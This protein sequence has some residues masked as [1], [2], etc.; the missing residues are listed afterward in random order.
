MKHVAILGST[1]SVG[2]NCLDVI[3]R[4]RSRFHVAALTTNTQTETLSIQIKEFEPT[5]CAIGD[6]E[7]ADELKNLLAGSKIQV[8]IGS[9]GVVEAAVRPEVDLVVNALVG[10]AGLL[11]TIKAIEAGKDIALANKESLVMAGELIMHMA[12]ESRIRLIPIDSEHSGILQCLQGHSSEEV[13]RI[14][15]TASGGPLLNREPIE[16]ESISPEEALA[17]PTWEMG[18]KITIDSASLMNKGLEV[19][20]AHWLFGVPLS[21][22][23]VVVHPQSIIHSLVEFTDGSILA[24]MGVPDM[25]VPIQLALTFPQRLNTPYNRLDL[26]EVR[27]LSFLQPDTHKFPCLKLAYRAAENGGTLP[28]VLNAANERA[29]Q[30][31]LNHRIAFTRIPV[32]IEEALNRHEKIDHPSLDEIMKADQWSRRFVQGRVEGRMGRLC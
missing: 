22:I 31:F 18:P 12:A 29:V 27:H 32:L 5:F 1:G 8:G 25:R 11:P 14:L 2:R 30:A 23:E 4:H 20:E 19:I 26:T 16:F 13:A 21:K 3:R 15:L 10:A 28:A 7:K 24:Q 17:H 9:E 6:G